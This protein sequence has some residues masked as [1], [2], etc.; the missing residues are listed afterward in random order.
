MTTCTTPLFIAIL[1]MALEV[2]GTLNAIYLSFAHYY[3]RLMVP[4][5]R[6]RQRDIINTGYAVVNFPYFWISKERV[7]RT[8]RAIWF[9]L[10]IAVLGSITYITLSVLMFGESWLQDVLDG[11]G[12]RCKVIV[13]TW[14]ISLV[15]VI[16]SARMMYIMFIKIG[17]VC[18]FCVFSA[19]TMLVLF[20]FNSYELKVLNLLTLP[21]YIPIVLGLIY[22]TTIN[23]SQVS[24]EV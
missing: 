2:L 10:P 12:L 13:I 24:N 14:A 19:C 21:I 22:R 7:V 9:E 6:A 16:F 8:G 17:K 18:P 20:T 11:C 15:G 4:R 5:Y 3:R 23:P 1:I